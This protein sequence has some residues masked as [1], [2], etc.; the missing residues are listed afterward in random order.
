YRLLLNYPNPFNPS[1]TT[2]FELPAASEVTLI[3]YDL[4]GREVTRL[5]DGGYLAGYH[6]V[7]WDGRN[8]SGRLLPSGI[9]IARLTTPG[10]SNSIKMLLLK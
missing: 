1:T 7:A 8:A 9:Y 2:G 6:Q 4:T 10:Y 3:V 5:A